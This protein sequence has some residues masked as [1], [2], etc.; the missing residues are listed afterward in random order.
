M[1]AGLRGRRYLGVIRLC[2]QHPRASGEPESSLVDLVDPAEMLRYR[3]SLPGASGYDAAAHALR[4]LPHDTDELALLPLV[5]PNSWMVNATAT[6]RTF[7]AWRSAEGRQA[8]GAILTLL[9]REMGLADW[10]ETSAEERVAIEAFVRVLA[11]SEGSSLAAVSKVLSLYR[12]HL[13]PLLDDAAIA[14]ALGTVAHPATADAPQADPR[15]FVPMLDWFAREHDREE[16]ALLELAR[17]HR[18]AVLD[19]AQVLDRLLWVASWGD[20]QRG[21]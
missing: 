9:P 15:W 5:F 8:F 20:A 21:R 4:L 6:S 7:R 2:R 16:P 3:A 13:V 10:L 19:T 12:P 18:E 11:R 1:T 14:F 17:G